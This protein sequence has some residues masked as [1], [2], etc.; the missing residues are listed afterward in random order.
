M[1]PWSSLCLLVYLIYHI[2]L[3]N[4]CLNYLCFIVMASQPLF[5]SC[6]EE[7]SEVE[8]IPAADQAVREPDIANGSSLERLN[9]GVA[10]EWM[11][12]ISSSLMTLQTSVSLITARQNIEDS[13]RKKKRVN[14]ISS[15][16]GSR[17]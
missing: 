8:Q 16:D 7:E 12:G 3:H 15:T 13:K 1:S 5:E 11:R 17:Y 6:D 4:V 10:A 9:A 2:I 14:H